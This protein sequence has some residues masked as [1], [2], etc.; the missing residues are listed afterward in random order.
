MVDIFEIIKSEFVLPFEPYSYQR[1]ALNK[2]VAFPNL[3]LPLKVGRGKTPIATWRVLFDAIAHNVN[4]GM[5][6]VPPPLVIQWY[7]WLQ[8]ITNTEGKGFKILAYQGS[9]EQRR[10]MDITSPDFLIMSRQIFVNDWKRINAELGK[11][12]D[13]H[14]VYDEAQEGLRHTG[15]KIWRYYNQFTLNKRTTLLSGTIV[16]QPGNVYAI[17][18]LLDPRIY[19]TRRNFENQHVQDMDYFGTITSWK[20]LELLKRNLY[21]NAVVIPDEELE[22]LPGLV[23]Q[24]IPYQLSS[25]HRK[26]YDEFVSEQLL[27]TDSG[28]VLDG[29]ETTRMFHALQRFVTSPDRMDFKKVQASLHDMLWSVYEED[30]SKLIVMAYYRDTNQSNFEFFLSKGV[31]AVGCWGEQNRKV[32]QASLDSFMNDDNCRVLVGNWGSFGVGTDGLQN[33]CFREVLAEM[34][35][36]PDRFEQLCGRIDRSGQKEKCI[37]KCLVAEDTIQETLF[38]ALM[39]KDDLLARITM[40][41]TPI[42]ELLLRR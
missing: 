39:N 27:T 18:K 6:I 26:L 8:R 30:D 24:S 13:I 42:R 40:Q 11:K 34:P 21:K 23:V 20:N 16:N 25:Q 4:H 19:P 31:N 10:D 29:T 38:N 9:P 14:V 2:S 15:N 7:R 33:V 28:E 32:Q 22:E 12:S 41:H 17:T 1:N 36:T 35:L 37:V 5:I 3:L